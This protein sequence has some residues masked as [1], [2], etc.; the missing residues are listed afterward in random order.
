MTWSRVGSLT[1]FSRIE[2]R[3]AC[4]SRCSASFAAF[5]L[6]AAFGAAVAVFRVLVLVVAI[7]MLL[8]I[9][10]EARHGLAA[11]IAAARPLRRIASAL[12]R[13]RTHAVQARISRRARAPDVNA[14]SLMRDN[15]A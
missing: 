9:P 13:S 3:R 7:R 5:G 6:A 14:R 8:S 12:G 2:A 1:C 10:G 4:W 15:L 11:A